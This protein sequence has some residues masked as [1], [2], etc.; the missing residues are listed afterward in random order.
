MKRILTVALLASTVAFS[1]CELLKPKKEEE[2]PAQTQATAG[3]GLDPATMVQAPGKIALGNRA[4]VG[5]GATRTQEASGQ[6]GVERYAIVGETDDAWQVELYTL[7]MSYLKASVPDIEEYVVG[8]LVEKETGKVTKAVLGKQGETGKEIQIMQAFEAD[9]QESPEG[10]MTEVSLA[11][12][13][14]F[15]AKN[16]TVADT[17]S[18][19]GTEGELDGVLLKSSGPGGDYELKSMPVQETVSIEGGDVKVT[20]FVYT[21]GMEWWLTPNEVVVTFFPWGTEGTQGMFKMV[22]SGATME[23]TGV[24]TDATPALAW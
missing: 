19:V 5:Y 17:T 23:V 10:K 7:G 20:K 6:T 8:A 13:G 12:G 18:W 16:V 15:K 21:N 9:A 24:K 14:P 3:G 2:Q 4:K 1:G 11:M 22:S